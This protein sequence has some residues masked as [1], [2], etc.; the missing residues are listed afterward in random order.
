MPVDS[1]YPD[2]SSSR[3]LRVALRI[4]SA[5]MS[6]NRVGAGERLERH[7]GG[8]PET[9]GAVG[10]VEGDPVAV[11]GDQGGAF[12]S[13]VPG[14]VRKGHASNLNVLVNAR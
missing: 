14:E 7:G 11:N 1:S 8:G 12:D 6:M 10:D 3:P 13:L 4:L 5:A 9:V 2:T